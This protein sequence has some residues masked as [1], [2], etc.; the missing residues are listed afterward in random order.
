MTVAIVHLR[1]FHHPP[2]SV[3]KCLT[4]NCYNCNLT[5]LF[6][7]ALFCIY[8]KIRFYLSAKILR[9]LYIHQLTDHLISYCFMTICLQDSIASSPLLNIYYYSIHIFAIILAI[10]LSQPCQPKSFSVQIRVKQNQTRPTC[11]YN[12]KILEHRQTN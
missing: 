7:V 11:K 10:T 8:V 12:S 3:K 2:I 9:N 5:I 6:V 1:L 4:K